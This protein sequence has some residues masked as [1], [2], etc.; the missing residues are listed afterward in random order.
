[1]RFVLVTSGLL[2]L[3][4]Q[5]VGAA[6]PDRLTQ[7]KNLIAEY[8][9]AEKK[10]LETAEPKD[11]TL[12]DRIRRYETWPLWNYAPRF[13]KLAEAKPDDEA[14]FLCCQWI[15][16][17][18]DS[19]GNE[20]KEIFDADQKA[21]EILAT[22]HTQR[23]DLPTLCLRAAQRFGH[24]REQFLRG[25]RR[26]KDLARENRGFATVALAELLAQKYE[27]IDFW[28]HRPPSKGEFLKFLDSRK[29]P[30][31]G[32]DLVSANSSKFRAES[33]DLFREVLTSYGDVPVKMSIPNFRRLNNL[34]DKATK[35]LHALEHLTV[36][37]PA[38]GIIGKD[39]HGR[40]LDLAAYR[41]RVVVLSFWFTGCGPCMAM[42]PQEQR[43]IKQY[44]GRPFALLS[45]CNDESRETAQK[46]AAAHKMEWPCWFDGQDG[47]IARNWNVLGWPAIYILNEKGVIVAK[48]LR[49]DSLDTK[50][51]ELMEKKK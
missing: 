37:S 23:P 28:E 21:W 15:L 31:W 24:A 48:Q 42:I 7:V 22:Y 5:I 14:A 29:S 38:P 6:D 19:G 18:T 33:I 27:E 39:L 2:A 9:A 43:L 41:G 30:N 13:V 36:G 44:Q 34:A 12:A 47:P 10:F 50:L 8:A 11:P 46:T 35:S 40:P 3:L 26:R 51:A 32:K 4:T 25:L 17:H 1:M 20:D 49:G 45:I 16:D